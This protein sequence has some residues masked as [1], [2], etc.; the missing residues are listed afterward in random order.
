VGPLLTQIA[1]DLGTT[2][3]ALGLLAAIPLIAFAAV[4]PLAHALSAR[5]GT[6]AVVSAALGALAAGVVWRSWPG[7]AANVWA[8][9]VL[10]GSAL[11]VANVLLPAVIKR[12]FSDRVPTVT[13]V[14]TAT[15]SGAGALASGVVV[16][17][18]HAEA[19]GGPLGWRWALL[20]SAA[21]VPVA[22]AVWAAAA[23]RRR[24]APSSAAGERHPAHDG[25][26]APSA[27]GG[28]PRLGIWGD[29][30]AW[31]VLAYM[32]VQAMTFYMLVTWLAPLSVST[33]RSEVVA[34][35]DVM[36]LQVSSLGGSLL[37]PFLLRGRLARWAPAIIP[38]FGL[39]A[40]VGLIAVP[41][42]FL[43]WVLLFGLASGSSLAT[44]FSLFSLRARTPSAAA[45]LSG[46]AQSG[47]YAIAAAGPVVFGGLL[48]ASGGWL[49]PLLFVVL[50]LAVQLVV[51]LGVG[52]ERHVLTGS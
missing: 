27:R 50:V 48:A 16:P 38:A 47:G 25:V 4:S 44:S 37:T 31:Q 29:A 30:V 39:A 40:L 45:R 14:F 26:G 23:P 15:L 24:R 9:T 35:T 46:M 7:A 42:L 21:A 33:G 3:T 36:L 5:F 19:G 10:V 51:G 2:E 52:R 32:G 43:A 34:G 17:V 13:S 18:S 28:A 12:D 41:A 11:A 1:A 22:M 8:G 6:T 20:A 49:V